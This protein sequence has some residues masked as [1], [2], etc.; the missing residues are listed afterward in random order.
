MTIALLRTAAVRRFLPV[1]VL[2]AV[3]TVAVQAS[4]GF[5]LTPPS[6]I[7]Q[8]DTGTLS[9]SLTNSG[10]NP[11]FLN[12]VSFHFLSAPAGAV[13]DPNDPNVALSLF[14]DANAPFSVAGT[15]DPAHPTVYTGPF[16]DILTASGAA[17]GDYDLRVTL[18]GGSSSSAGDPLGF[19]DIQQSVASPVSAPVPELST[20]IGFSLMVALG[21]CGLLRRRF[22]TQ[23]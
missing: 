1:L 23:P 22:C 9:G 10:P 6:A 15:S 14:F 21:F 12:G 4:V 5:T 8:G 20:S 11:V 3:T 17:V 19:Y 13:S 2:L 7:T 16:F 18:Q